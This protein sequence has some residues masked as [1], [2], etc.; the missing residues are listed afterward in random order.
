MYFINKKKFK[1]LHFLSSLA[2]SALQDLQPF[3]KTTTT[4]K[5]L[6]MGTQNWGIT[7]LD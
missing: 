6:I 5:L 1:V 7:L 2:F 4:K 3:I